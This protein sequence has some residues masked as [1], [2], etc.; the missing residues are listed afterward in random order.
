MSPLN[1]LLIKKNDILSVLLLSKGSLNSSFYGNRHGRND[2]NLVDTFYGCMPTVLICPDMTG[3][4]GFFAIQHFYGHFRA[5]YQWSLDIAKA[6]EYL[7]ES[8]WTMLK[9]VYINLLSRIF[10]FVSCV[11]QDARHRRDRT[12]YLNLGKMKHFICET[13]R[14]ICLN[15]LSASFIILS[16]LFRPLG[17]ISAAP[18]SKIS[19]KGSSSNSNSKFGDAKTVIFQKDW[20]MSRWISSLSCS[21]FMQ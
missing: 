15:L 12:N 1:M 3:V 20:I 4:Y 19:C 2:T 21:A 18:G 8:K 6:N 7:S 5:D 13:T 14:N 11:I 9:S 17:S 16:K 10:S